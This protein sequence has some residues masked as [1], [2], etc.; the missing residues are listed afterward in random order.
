MLTELTQ[1]IEIVHE[2]VILQ[3]FESQSM[4]PSWSCVLSESRLFLRLAVRLIKENVSTHNTILNLEKVLFLRIGYAED[5][6][7]SQRNQ[8]KETNMLSTNVWHPVIL[9]RTQKYFLTWVWYTCNKLNFM[10]AFFY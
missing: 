9:Y 10:K 6:Q 7:N 3:E 4:L 5:E 2:F 8:R 1:N